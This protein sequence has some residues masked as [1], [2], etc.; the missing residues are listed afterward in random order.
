MADRHSERRDGSFI[1]VWFDVL[2]DPRRRSLCQYLMQTEAEIVT[3]EELVEHVCERAVDDIDA[4]IDRRS[5]AMELRHVHLPK[6]NSLDAVEYDPQGET[7]A[8][9]SET[10]STT[11][12]E[13][14]STIE[15]IQD[16]QFDE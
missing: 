2:S 12:A 15:T 1:D 11:L 7:V 8:V 10:I 13:L 16:G 3:H 5:L 4:T 14:Q 6:L 9:D